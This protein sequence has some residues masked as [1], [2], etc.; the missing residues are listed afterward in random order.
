MNHRFMVL[1]DTKMN[2]QKVKEC[3]MNEFLKNLL[4]KVQKMRDENAACAQDMFFENGTIAC[5]KEQGLKSVAPYDELIN[6]IKSRSGAVE[7]HPKCP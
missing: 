6:E 1:E 3:D 5:S 7:A 2:T 4:P